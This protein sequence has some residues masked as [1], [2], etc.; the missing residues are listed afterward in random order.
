MTD[1]AT[2]QEQLQATSAELARLNRAIAENPG[3]DSLV[4]MTRSVED[5]HKALEQTFLHE[6]NNLGI[7]VCNYRLIGENEQPR[8]ASVARAL[9]TF[10]SLVS[11][12]YAAVKSGAPRM[13]GRLSATVV[14]ESSFGFGYTYPG[15]LGVVLTVPNERFL[16]G[17]SKLDESVSV[18]FNM[19]RSEQSF[20]IAQYAETLG[21]AAVRAMH[22][23]STALAN[24]GLG[25][26]IEW[27]RDAHVQA[28]L[29]MQPPEF[30]RLAKTIEATGD[31]VVA[32]LTAFGLLVGIDTAR[33]TFHLTF[34][35][36]A[37]IRGKLGDAVSLAEPAHVPARYTAWLTRTTKPRYAVEQD[38]IEWTLHKL[39]LGN[40]SV[41]ADD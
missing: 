10:Q 40:V 27:W 18:V 25:A 36:A 28:E 12:V 16:V 22:K 30:D 29:V 32:E 8:A 20:E 38:E 23:W 34:E 21:P 1:L 24:S 31:P 26:D 5:Q 33:R 14:S 3:S 2:L 7:D 19:A 17:E 6:A 39:E 41:E 13:A 9:E 4:S 35:N 37:D 15:S 11:T